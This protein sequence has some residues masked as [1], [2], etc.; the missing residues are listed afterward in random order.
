MFVQGP[1][2]A[3][4]GQLYCTCCCCLSRQR[5]E[6]KERG[7]KG[8]FTS[9]RPGVGREQN[10]QMNLTVGTTLVLTAGLEGTLP[11]HVLPD[12]TVV[13]DKSRDKLHSPAVSPGLLLAV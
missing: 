2:S 5:G 7:P 1:K 4:V 10:H 6:G 12:V 13:Q 8:D 3:V 11:V 9:D